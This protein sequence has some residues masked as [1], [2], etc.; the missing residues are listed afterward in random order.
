MRSNIEKRSVGTFGRGVITAS[1]HLSYLL[2]SRFHRTIPIIFVTGY[3]KG[4]TVW[5]CQMISDYLQLPFA[6][7]SLFP[8]TFPSVM[9][10]HYTIKSKG[11][12]A[13]YVVRD[14][15]DTILSMYFYLSRAL[16]TGDNPVVPRRFRRSF[17]GIV[18]RDRVRDNLPKFIEAQMRRPE[19]C[20]V[21]WGNHVRSYCESGRTDVPMLK[22][23]QMLADC[24]K[25]LSSAIATLTGEEPDPEG[26]EATVRKYA[27]QRQAGRSQGT[28]NRSSFLR[29]GQAG[30]WRNHFTPE[31]ARVFHHW[32]G[33]ELIELGYEPNDDWVDS[34]E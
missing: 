2:A 20:R 31:A 9:H 24:P 19:G 3:P 30:D 14:G 13:V 1:H 21:P 8:I 27:F 11:P 25:A 5:A 18:N 32:C 22:Y 28:E 10:G 29:K 23:E 33:R 4:G 17:P 34:V 26:I 6:D 15:R 16:P 12:R 7:Q